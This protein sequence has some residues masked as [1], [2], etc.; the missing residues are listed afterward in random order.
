MHRAPAAVAMVMLLAW[1]SAAQRKSEFPVKIHG[2]LI[3]NLA[4]RTRGERPPKSE[5][6]AFVLGEERL[7]LDVSGATRTGAAFFLVKGDVFHDAVVNRADGDLR[8]GYVGYHRGAADLRAGRQILT[9]GVGDLFFIN[10]V[11]PKDW[12]SFFSGRPMEYLKRGVDAFRVQYSSAALNTDLVATPFF[13]PDA[14]PSSK[15]FFLYNPLVGVANEQEI[16]PPARAEN[17][18][19]ALRLYRRV[20]GFDVS[21]YGYRGFWRTPSVVPTSQNGRRYAARF[22]PRLVVWGVSAQHNWLDGVVSLEGGHYHS[23]DDRGGADPTIPNSEWR[24]LAA[25]QRQIG[26]EL[27]ANFQGYA[28][29]M[30]R[31]SAYRRS[32][33]AGAPLPDQARA[34]FSVRLTQFWGY[35]SWKFSAF[36]AHSPTDN[37][38]FLQPE[39]SHR[40]TDRLSV[41]MGAN[42]F[43]GRRDTTFFGQMKKDDNVY[44]SARFDF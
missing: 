35:Q 34:V 28:E 4:V 10:D 21:L 24:F 25:Y 19:L 31:Y 32:L 38:Y 20:A 36:L 8:E 30:E 29:I 33:P 22:Y 7:R 15:R 3:G 23:R 41:A 18:E 1:P 9:W 5:G 44:A 6:G 17:T 37:D 14:L 26:R 43:G 42:L 40:L 2:F 39:V 12:Q 11:F 16:I 13:T 27:T